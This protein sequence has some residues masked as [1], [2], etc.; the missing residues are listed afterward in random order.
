[1]DICGKVANFKKIDE[2]MSKLKKLRVIG[3]MSKYFLTK[4]S[5]I[6]L[7]VL[8]LTSLFSQNK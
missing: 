4:E 2:F 3:F 8:N 1:L 5:I 7:S 6:K